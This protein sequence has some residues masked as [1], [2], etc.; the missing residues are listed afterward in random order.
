MQVRVRQVEQLVNPVGELH[1]RV[2]PH[3]AEDGCALERS[4]RKLVKLAKERGAADVGHG[5]VLSYLG[6]VVRTLTAFEPADS[7]SHSQDAPAKR[8]VRPEAGSTTRS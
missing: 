1:V 8:T 3:L 4:I 2:A 6:C 5:S 7:N